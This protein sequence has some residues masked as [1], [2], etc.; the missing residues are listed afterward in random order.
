MSVAHLPSPSEGQDPASSAPCPIRIHPE[1]PKLF[2]F[3]GRPLVLVTATEHYGAVMNR[4]FRYNR[5]LEDA[6]GKGMTLTRLFT[7]FR[8]LQAPTNPYST[9]KPE[10]TDYVAPFERIGPDLAHD[11]QPKYDLTRWNAEFF[12]RLHGFLQL[13]S[14]HG[15]VVEVVLLS[16]SYDENIWKLN[17]L[18]AG[19]NINGTEA[20]T[21]PEIMTRRH[22]CLFE[23]QCAHARK[24]VEE[25]RQYDNVIYEIC[26]EPG[27]YGP[28]APGKPRPEEV[29]AWLSDLVEVIRAADTPGGQ[30]HLIAGQ[31]ASRVG[32]SFASSAHAVDHALSEMPVDIANAHPLPHTQYKGEDYDLGW[33]MSGQLRLRELQRFMLDTYEQPRPLNLDEDNAATQ[34]RDLTGWTVHRKRAWTTLFCGGHYDMIDFSIL[35]LRETGTEESNRCLRTWFGHLAMFV[36][37]IDLVHAR[38]LPG[39]LQ[40]DRSEI[41]ASVFA[42]EGRNYCFYLADGRETGDAGCGDPL[43][44]VLSFDLPDTPFQVA[45]FSPVTGLHSPWIDFSGGTRCRLETPVFKHDLVV[46]LRQRK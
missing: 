40:C 45:M 37:E 6:A 44:T 15:I 21:W 35:P 30:G 41:V 42:I 8:E 20:C 26:N 11:G 33:F 29:N 10:S 36:H 18:H 23:W 19:N 39:W 43:A 24:I 34:Y 22:P 13:A 31:E 12:Q 17:P 46:H 27:G 1:H 38:P 9:C 7:L 5:Y 14:D 28:D 25:T 2:E 16:N 3:R 4:P 32:D